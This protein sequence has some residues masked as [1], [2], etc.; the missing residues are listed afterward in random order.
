MPF[1][2]QSMPHKDARDRIAGLPLVTRGMMDEMLPELRAYAFCITGLDVGDEL[3]KARDEIAAVPMGAKTWAQARKSIAA[4]LTE[5]LGGKKAERR[6]ELLLRTHVFRGYAAARYRNLMQQVDVFPYW[7]YKTHGDGNV[8]PSHL[9]LN[10][11]IFPAGHDIWQRIFPPWD[12]GCRCLVVPLTRGAVERMQAGGMAGP[13]QDGS[14]IKTQISKPELFTGREA[15]LIAQAQKLPDGTPLNH[16]QTWASAPWSIPGNIRHDWPLIQK[17]YADQPEVLE[18]FEKWARKQILPGQ[19]KSV[20]T[21]IAGRAKPVKKIKAPKVEE[22][23]KVPAA[24]A[25]PADVSGL[26]PVKKLG[27]STGAMLVEDTEGNRWVMKKGASAE[28]LREE[29]LADDLYRQLGSPV[30]EVKLYETDGG[31]VKLARWIEGESLA[32]MLKKATPADRDALLVKLREHFHLDVLL[33][34]W[35][36]VGLAKDNILVDAAGLP[37]RIDN[38][39]SLRFRAMGGLKN[40]DWNEIPDELF[41]LRDAAKNAQ[42]AEIFGGMRLTEIARKVEG[43]DISAL[44]APAEVKAMLDARWKNL[45]DV[46]NKALDMEHD[47]WRDSYGESLCGHIFGLR[48]AGI[49]ADLPKQILQAPGTVS[50]VDENGKPWDDLRRTKTASAA[51]ATIKGDAYWNDIL[52][53]AKT[54]NHHAGTG[55]FAYNQTKVAAALKHKATLEKMAKGKGDDASM[56]KHYL[57]ALT[58]IEAGVQNSA[59][60]VKFSVPNL[61]AWSPKPPPTPAPSK[62]NLSL[63]ERL[64]DYMAANGA[65]HAAVT[66]WKGSQSGSSWGADAQ[67]KKAW[68]AKHMNIP[69]KDVYW[70]Q[71]P[72]TAAAHLSSM[73]KS[74]GAGAVD[75]AFTIHH[76][77]VQEMLAA[78][79]IRHNDRAMR[80]MRLIR[81]ESKALKATYGLK[82][83]KDA[84]IPRGMCESS[85]PFRVTTVYGSEVTIQA[86]P[87]SRI[88]GSYLMEKTPGAGDCG[89]LGDGENEFTF[90]A[91]GLPFRYQ[92]TASKVITSVDAG[93]DATKWDALI[94]HLRTFKPSTP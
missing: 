92:G 48:K 47:G 72:A 1:T 59:Q 41:T 18:A 64:R 42:T 4:D 62:S 21:W 40:A 56:A 82:A 44:Q 60:K 5:G 52:G 63:V 88:L 35:D 26:K 85:S 33:G 29:V 19:K 70:G 49:S 36:V 91:A 77:F 16:A 30:P 65:D 53:A 54:L 90:V 7:Q 39:G 34:N 83:G 13:E 37:W 17:R 45:S 75:S 89:F 31:P 57:H 22:A 61:L 6:A 69:A 14:L 78:T 20:W 94:L 38:G 68:V 55:A 32:E 23:P 15:D 87:H 10:R 93:D 25:F 74:L 58:H 81:T 43:M 12:W 46:A 86:V 79:E 2:F 71:S 67:A 27:G 9:A 11:K 84:A 24:A 8:R 28:H 3:A 76:A 51:A 50:V 73:E 66:R 80:A